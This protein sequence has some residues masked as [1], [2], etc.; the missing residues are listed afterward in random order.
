MADEMS[1]FLLLTLAPDVDTFVITPPS[2]CPLYVFHSLCDH[3][4]GGSA[5]VLPGGWQYTN[6]LVISAQ[7]VNS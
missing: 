4:A 6:S 1:L 2:S 5:L 3:S 7:S